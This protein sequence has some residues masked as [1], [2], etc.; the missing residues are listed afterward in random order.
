MNE[1]KSNHNLAIGVEADTTKLTKKLRAIAKH[2]E[3]LAD[4]LEAID[5]WKCD[6]GSLDYHEFE[7]E[8]KGGLFRERTC[9]ECGEKCVFGINRAT[10]K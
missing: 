10:E 4:E 5:R 9:D 8:V 1:K 7:F 6:C 3:A 2:A